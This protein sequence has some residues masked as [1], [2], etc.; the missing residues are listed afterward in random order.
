MNELWDQKHNATKSFVSE[1][2]ISYFHFSLKFSFDCAVIRNEMENVG[3]SLSF[4]TAMRT[5]ENKKENVKSL[6]QVANSCSQYR[7]FLI[8]RISG[9]IRLILSY[10]AC[11]RASISR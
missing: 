9:H 10:A 8:N 5:L 11:I 3:R 4:Q 6:L 2:P 1:I 7:F